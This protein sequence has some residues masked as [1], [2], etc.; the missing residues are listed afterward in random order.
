VDIDNPPN[1]KKEQI[2]KDEKSVSKILNTI[3]INIHEK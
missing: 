1:N 3:N 2:K